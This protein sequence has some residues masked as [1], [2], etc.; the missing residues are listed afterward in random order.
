RP[1]RQRVGLPRGD[2]ADDGE[3]V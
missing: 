1:G 3:C 2:R